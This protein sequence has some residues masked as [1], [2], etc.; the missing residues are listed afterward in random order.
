MKHLK[1]NQTLSR[2][3][4]KSLKSRLTRGLI[5]R[6]KLVVFKKFIR[7]AGPV[8]VLVVLYV[9]IKRR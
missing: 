8:L 4:I 5:R 6:L 9:L 7:V 2:K 3:M 1:S